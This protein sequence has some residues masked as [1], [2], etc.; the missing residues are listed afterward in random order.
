[1]VKKFPVFMT[2][3]HF[4]VYSPNYATGRQIVSETSVLY[5]LHFLYQTRIR[6]QF[7]PRFYILI[8]ERF[9]YRPKTMDKHSATNSSS[10]AHKFTADLQHNTKKNK[11]EIK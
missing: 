8:L 6:E 3:R 9:C 7:S 11:L 4:L 1:M 5:T 2:T 10:V